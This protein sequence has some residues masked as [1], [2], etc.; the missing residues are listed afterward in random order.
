VDVEHTGSHT[1]FYDKFSIRYQV[2]TILEAAWDLQPYRQA[3]RVD[4]ADETRFM[5]FVNMLLNDANHLL[6]ETLNNLE[7]IHKLE[8]LINSTDPEW[9]RLTDKEKEEKNDRLNSLHDQ[10]RSYNQLSNNN[11]KLLFLLTDDEVV[12]KVF[13]RPEMVSR[14]AEMLNYLLKRLCGDRCRDLKVSNADRVAWKPRL[15]LS[16]VLKTFL[17]FH[18]D[19]AFAAAVGRDGRSYSSE[20]LKRAA[21]IAE[22]RAILHSTDV[23]RFKAIA[24]MAAQVLVEDEEDDTD[25]GD[26]P[27][28]FLDPIM[29]SIME[30]PVRLPTSANVMDRDVISRILLSDKLDPFNRAFLSEDMLEDDVE[31]KARITAFRESRRAAARAAKRAKPSS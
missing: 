6:D 13:L 4:A 15:L 25:L 30:N 24:A 26:I 2:G 9:T 3:I 28:E 16:R 17:H 27:E 20:L 29:N 10:A 18:E 21:G 11:V 1:Q 14:I 5:R 31:L 22:R 19:R 7:E 23:E 12:R 8:K